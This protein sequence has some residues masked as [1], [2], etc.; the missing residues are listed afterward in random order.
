MPP[1]PRRGVHLVSLDAPRPQPRLSDPGAGSGAAAA[2]AGS[3]GNARLCRSVCPA[4]MGRQRDERQPVCFG[5]GALCQR[6]VCV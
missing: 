3:N 4:R 5:G 6:D 1:P 2:S